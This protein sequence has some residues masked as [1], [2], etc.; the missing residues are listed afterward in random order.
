MLSRFLSNRAVIRQASIPIR[1]LKLHEYQ[2][3]ALLHSYNVPIPIGK[4]AFS[5]EEALTEANNFGKEHD[6]YVVKAQ[7]LGGGRGL[8]HFKETGFKSG[9]HI[10][11]TPAKVGAL[12]SEMIGKSLVTKQSGEEGFPC[13]AV[14]IV[15]KLGIQKELYLSITLDRGAGCPTF[16]YSPAGGMAIED[17]AHNTPEAIYKMPV[18]MDKGLDAAALHQAAINL[19]LEAHSDQV[20]SVFQ[21]IYDCFVA[22]DCDM[23]EI[24]PLVLTNDNKVLA[25]DSKITVDSNA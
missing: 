25:A 18:N 15:E 22:R 6:A 19:G 4:V 24:N 1:G 3:G 23:I 5:A 2:A 9:V 11:D 8:G 13:S 7:V 21:A 12:S 10:V 14:Y 20:A 17:V 16:I